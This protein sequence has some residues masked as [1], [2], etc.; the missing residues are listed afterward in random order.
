MNVSEKK[1]NKIFLQKKLGLPENGN[2]PMYI[3]I[4]RLVE[5]KG[6]HLLQAI[7]DEFL[8]EDVQFVLLGTGDY[9]FEDFFLP[10]CRT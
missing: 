6:L 1:E 10:C 8:Q 9:L 3:L 5:Q 7:I 4:S 2:V